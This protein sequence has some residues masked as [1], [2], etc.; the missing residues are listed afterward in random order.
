[1]SDQSTGGSDGAA[2]PGDRSA[3]ADDD[4]D[5]AEMFKRATGRCPLGTPPASAP[6]AR[7]P[8]DESP[9]PGA[10]AGEEPGGA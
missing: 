3:V 1:M 4:V 2:R 10:P 9:A 8:A 5:F 7:G 6:A